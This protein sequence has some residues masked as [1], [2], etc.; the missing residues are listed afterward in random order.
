MNA[1]IRQASTIRGL[2]A[3]AAPIALMTALLACP[4]VAS[5]QAQNTGPTPSA[6]PAARGGATEL[7]EIVVTARKREERLRDIPTAA[8]ALSAEA[9]QALGGIAT[10]QSLLTNTPGVNFANTSN[11]VTSEVSIRGSGTSRA[12]TAESG[13]G[14]FRD[15]A[16]IGGGTVAGRT[17]TDLDLF[18]V[19]RIEVLRGVQGGLNGRNAE[20]GAVNV[21]S[22]RPTQKFEGFVNGDVS[23]NNREEGQVVVNLPINEHWAVRLGADLMDQSKGFYKL[24]LRD[25]YADQQYKQFYRGQINFSQGIFTANLL[26]EHGNE[27]LPG[28]VYQLNTFP[29]A[30]YPQGFSQD[31]FSLPWNSPSNAK[32]RMDNYEFATSTDLPF[33]SINTTSMY[34][35]RHGQNAYDRDAESPQYIQQ[36]IS[37]G[38]VAPGAIPTVLAGDYSLGGNQQDFAKIFYQDVHL[39][40]TKI[41]GFSWLAGAEYYLLRDLPSSVLSKSPTL[42]NPST[43]TI[44]V[45]H[46]RFESYA[47]YGSAGYDFTDKF[48][49]SADLRVTH[50]DEDFSTV[51]NDFGTGRPASNGA[52]FDIA[53]TQK[54][55]NVSYTVTASYKPVADWL[56][57]AKIGS[58]FRPGGFNT[59]LGDPR[60]PTPVPTTYATETLTAYEVGFKGN[61]A[62]NIYLT[63]SVYDNEFDNLIIQGQNGC[64]VASPVCPVQQ[65]VFAFNAGPAS[66]WGVEFEGTARFQVL[67]GDLHLSIGGSRQGGKIGKGIYDGL[68]QPQQP[69]WTA[70]FNVNYRHELTDA[71]TG[72]I[73]VKG[74]G[75][76][77]GVQ[78]IAQTPNLADYMSVDARAGVDWG[79]YELALHAENL[80]N[81]TYEVFGAP[82]ALN[83][84]VRYN[85]PRTYGIQLRY[86][87]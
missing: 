10:A 11:P 53:G 72:F 48:N 60:Q 76:W 66:L 7:E 32:L 28:L 6:T 51:R 74:N 47:V 5:A 85:F 69:D 59:S 19:E 82:T 70:T 46:E 38:K 79:N 75:R 67:D 44:D 64:F 24:P 33:A 78:E 25:E 14:L 34:R 84:V 8:T 39:T 40:G 31:R 18:D 15:G 27:Q 63:A 49:V 57:Y 23:N 43:G 87:W 4:A 80:F 12:T 54:D 36:L 2:A 77:G 42:A 37:Q 73:N 56:V 55:T 21:V 65:T 9:I 17:F 26:A 86:T 22:A 45:G 68:R 29:S 62:S 13:V 16:F 52:A 3:H 1:S 30:T 81:T 71:L 83:N 50:D 20:G 41:G 35:E 58:A 61:L